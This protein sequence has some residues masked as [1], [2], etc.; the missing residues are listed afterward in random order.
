MKPQ[1]SDDLKARSDNRQALWLSRYL[2]VLDWGLHYRREDLAG[3]VIAGVIAAI[4]LIPQSMAYALLAGLPVQVGLYASILPLILYA[5][6]GTSRVLSVGPVAIVALLTP[7]PLPPSPRP[8][9]RPILPSP[10]F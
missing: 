4:M 9:P 1:S 8:T 6:L 3:D 2:P 7:K 5:V 10:W